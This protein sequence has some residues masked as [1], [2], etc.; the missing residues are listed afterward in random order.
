EVEKA[1]DYLNKITIGK[2]GLIIRGAEGSGLLLPQVFTE[3]N[4]T[5]V[6]A[7]EMTCKKAGLERDA[8]Q[9][10]S[11]RIFRFEAHVY[12]EDTK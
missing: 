10:L 2:H 7:L 5:V 1:E 6:S 4:C 8:W 12:S 9:D 3:Y 11:N